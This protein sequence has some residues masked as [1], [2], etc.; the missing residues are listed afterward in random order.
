YVY[1]HTEP[2]DGAKRHQ[3]LDFNK[4]RKLEAIP[5]FKLTKGNLSEREK[6][7][8]R[9][10]IQKGISQKRTLQE[11]DIYTPP[12]YDRMYFEGMMILEEESEYS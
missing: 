10:R 12:K 9:K 7:E 11:I 3:K 8:I 1:F 6:E 2:M 4:V 5:Q